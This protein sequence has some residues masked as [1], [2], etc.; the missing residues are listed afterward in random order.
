MQAQQNSTMTPKDTQTI[1]RALCRSTIS[2]HIKLEK[3]GIMKNV[4]FIH[5]I[6]A[7]VSLHFTDL[8][9][10]VFMS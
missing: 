3:A 1:A 5:E 2:H 9:G 10:H 4:N 7:C 6:H 8:C